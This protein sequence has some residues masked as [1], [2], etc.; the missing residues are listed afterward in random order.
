MIRPTL[1]SF[2]SVCVLC[3]FNNKYYG[4]SFEIN[5]DDDNYFGI[6]IVFQ[7]THFSMC[8]NHY[9]VSGHAKDSITFNLRF[10][11]LAKKVDHNQ[12]LSLKEVKSVK[13]H[14]AWK[15]R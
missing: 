12:E 7:H 11:E 9:V 13:F 10:R 3:V 2:L 5:L 15:R 14:L 8:K 4:L 1:L 6:E